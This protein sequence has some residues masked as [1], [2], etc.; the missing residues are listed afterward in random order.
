MALDGR[1]QPSLAVEDS[2]NGKQAAE[3]RA[4]LFARA[5]PPVLRHLAPDHL[6]LAIQRRQGLATI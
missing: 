6:G 5:P 1:R 4:Q 2:R 3:G